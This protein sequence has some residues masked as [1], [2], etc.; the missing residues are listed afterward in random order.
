MTSKARTIATITWG[1]QPMIRL[2]EMEQLFSACRQC[3]ISFSSLKL[4]RN[5]MIKEFRV[6]LTQS[7]LMPGWGKRSG[8]LLGFLT[9]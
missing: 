3:M 5:V 6:A 8:Y 4:L 1:V 7:I 9:K 2:R